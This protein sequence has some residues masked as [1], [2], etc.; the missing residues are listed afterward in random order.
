M[1]YRTARGIRDGGLSWSARSPGAK[2]N[3]SF[4]RVVIVYIVRG[5]Q[6][7]RSWCGVRISFGW[8]RIACDGRACA[9][10]A[11]WVGARCWIDRTGHLEDRLFS[12]ALIAMAV[13]EGLSTAAV[14]LGRAHRI[15]ELHETLRRW[16]VGQHPAQAQR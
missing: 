14:L 16:R 4:D 12:I 11:L 3:A 1:E 6:I 8:G 5:G 13:R 10:V 15:H 2:S 7:S 9:P